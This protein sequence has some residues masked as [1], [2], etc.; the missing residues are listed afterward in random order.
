M[1]LFP[2]KRTTQMLTLKTIDTNYAGPLICKTKWG[3]ETKVHILFT[4]SLTS[5]VHLEP[6]LNQSTEEFIMTLK[7]VIARRGRVSVIYSDN[8]KTFVAA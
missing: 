1:K 3:K 8:V 7:R 6:L 5:V 2:G 4:C